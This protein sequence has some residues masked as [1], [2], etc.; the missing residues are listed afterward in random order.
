MF[1]TTFVLLVAPALAGPQTLD[2]RVKVNAT[3][4]A[5]TLEN[6]DEGIVVI[7]VVDL[8]GRL[9]AEVA[10]LPKVTEEGVVVIE[11]EVVEVDR[12]LLGRERRAVFARPTLKTWPGTMTVLG[13]GWIPEDRPDSFRYRGIEH[14]EIVVTPRAGE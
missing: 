1:P 4:D 8:P 12:T 9:D 13:Q 3:E 10:L 5:W 2:V 14:Y 11:V 6:A 7:E